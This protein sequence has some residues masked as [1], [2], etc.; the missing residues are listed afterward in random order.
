MERGAPVGLVLNPF[1]AAILHDLSS[2]LVIL[3]SSRLARYEPAAAAL[4]EPTP[5]ASQ[6]PEREEEVSA[7]VLAIKVSGED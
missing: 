4:R 3:N 7:T 2:V 1:I 6:V 5:R